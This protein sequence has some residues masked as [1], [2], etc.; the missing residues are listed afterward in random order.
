MRPAEYADVQHLKI[1]YRESLQ[2]RGLDPA[3]IEKDYFEYL[4]QHK[5]ALPI[6]I[7]LIPER[8]V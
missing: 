4:E 3:Q 2:K 1:D 7:P 6:P 5:G 8:T